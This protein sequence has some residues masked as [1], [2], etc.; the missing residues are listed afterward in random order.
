MNFAIVELVAYAHPRTPPLLDA[1]TD[2]AN[3][4]R[5]AR[6]SALAVC[7]PAG[8][9]RAAPGGGARSAVAGPELCR[10]RADHHGE[11]RQ[12]GRSRVVP[13][14]PELVDA[15]RSVPKGR[16]DDRY[17]HFLTGPRSGGSRREAT[18]SA[19]GCKVA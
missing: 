1:G 18:A 14:H 5:H 13:A 6:R 11:E 12:G 10:R 8:A 19:T 4:G 9:L 16:A 7:P 3:S 17:S 2:R 15:F